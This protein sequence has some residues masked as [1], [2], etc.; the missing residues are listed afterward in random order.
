[1]ES[2]CPWNL[3]HGLEDRQEKTVGGPAGELLHN[4]TCPI[5]IEKS[6]VHGQNP[7]W[8]ARQMD[9]ELAAAAAGTALI[10]FP[11]GFWIGYR[12]RDCISRK[13]RTRY[14]VDRWEREQRVAREREAAEAAAALAPQDDLL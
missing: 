13:R 2:I 9:V 7:R 4:S 3:I 6:Q 5:T 10:V 12:V 8:E 14:W 1:L 11:L